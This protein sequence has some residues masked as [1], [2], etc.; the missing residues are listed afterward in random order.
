MTLSQRKVANYILSS[1]SSKWRTSDKMH[2]CTSYENVVVVGFQLNLSNRPLLYCFGRPYE[3]LFVLD[4]P[5]TTN[6]DLCLSENE[7]NK[8]YI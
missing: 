4:Y 6:M 8:E 1:D 3:F 5:M 2:I 7:K